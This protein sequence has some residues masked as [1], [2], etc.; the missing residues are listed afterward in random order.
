MP[1][2]SATGACPGAPRNSLQDLPEPGSSWDA[3]GEGGPPVGGHLF[4]A[5][6][7]HRALGPGEQR[8]LQRHHR[9]RRALSAGQIPRL[10]GGELLRFAGAHQGAAAPAPLCRRAHRHRQQPCG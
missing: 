4:R 1:T 10:H 3:K 7:P 6:H 2:A 9:R 8:R 5:S